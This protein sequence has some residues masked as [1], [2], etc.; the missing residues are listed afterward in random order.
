MGFKRKLDQKEEGIPDHSTLQ[1]TSRVTRLVTWRKMENALVWDYAS[2]SV[3]A[4][5]D[6]HLDT[7]TDDD[8]ELFAKT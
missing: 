4:D 1:F 3:K 7:D 2:S 6:H 8:E 5:S